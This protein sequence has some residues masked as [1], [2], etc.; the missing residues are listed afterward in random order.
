MLPQ[1]VNLSAVG[2]LRAHSV[3]SLAM[4]KMGLRP[5]VFLLSHTLLAADPI[6]RTFNLAVVAVSGMFSLPWTLEARVM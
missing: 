4:G 1:R 5:D 3:D 2:S 6:T